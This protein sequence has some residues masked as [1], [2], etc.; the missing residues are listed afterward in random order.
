MHTEH[1]DLTT[2]TDREALR[3][4][5]AHAQ[6]KGYVD[7]AYVNALLEREA[8]YPTGL[9]VSSA[10]FGLAIPHA[11][12][13]HVSEQAVIIGLPAS[14]ASVPFISMDNPNH[15]VDAE[16]VVLLL[17]TETERYAEFLSNLVKLFSDR[18]FGN[19][20]RLRDGEALGELIV[21]RCL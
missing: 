17:V 9:D 16:V 13:D 14:D 15:T 18:T 4:L 10:G 5:A 11:D 12:P 1:I 2:A 21:E 8:T 3:T 19:L 6:A 7:N 20:V